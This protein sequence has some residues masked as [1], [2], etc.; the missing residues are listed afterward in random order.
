MAVAYDAVSSATSFT[1]PATS[2]TRTWSHTV[3][4]SNLGIYIVISAANLVGSVAGVTCTCTVNGVSA[5]GVKSG[6]TTETIYQSSSTSGGLFC[7]YLIGPT[8]GNIVLTLSSAVD[9]IIA[10]AV[11]FTG[12]D[13]IS[14]VTASN[15]TTSNGA[16]NSPTITLTS[17]T[18]DMVICGAAHGDTISGVGSGTTQ[19]FLTNV[20]SSTSSDNI[21]GGTEPGAASVSIDFTSSVSDHWQMIAANFKAAAAASSGPGM[22]ILPP[23]VGPMSGPGMS[24][25]WTQIVGVDATTAAAT[26]APAELASGTG[27][28]SNASASIAPNAGNAAGTG[29]AGAAKVTVAPNAGNAAGTGAANAAAASIAPGAGGAAGTGAAGGPSPSIAPVAGN[30]AGT[31][32]AYDATASTAAATNANAGL[33]SGTGAAG[34]ASASI[35]PN[36]GNAS[37]TGS[38]GGSTSEV[39]PTA[40]AA[41][42]TGTSSTAAPAVAPTA[43]AASGTGTAYNAT[44]TVT[45]ATNAQAGLASGTGTAFGA[46]TKVSVT[47]G[48]AIATATAYSATVG[49]PTIPLPGVVHVWR[50]P[51]VNRW[52]EPGINRWRE[53]GTMT[54]GE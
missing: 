5:T 22:S 2:N 38:A 54:G 29:A 41:T 49:Q 46:T 6:T 37:G 52:Q 34:D 36:G 30:A 17:A 20:D 13:S 43:G 45:G 4:G 14:T 15:Y 25:F 19:R 16:T 48:V 12:T 53:P 23:D 39:S 27:A 26:N 47:A 24:P 8:S 28:A 33:A 3:T 9:R 7:F 21:V 35:A 11:S 1:G 51:G 31:G 44:A 40:G 42:G 10:S 18:G 32:T 50:E